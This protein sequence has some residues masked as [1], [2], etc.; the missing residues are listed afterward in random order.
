MNSINKKVKKS[1]LFLLLFI[2]GCT[3]L[4][5]PALKL[6]LNIEGTLLVRNYSAKSGNY[7]L[8][9]VS[10]LPWGW[11]STMLRISPKKINIGAYNWSNEQKKIL[12][13]CGDDWEKIC[14][15]NKYGLNYKELY[16]LDELRLE[17]QN[18]NILTISPNGKYLTLFY[19]GSDDSYKKGIY[20]FDL[21]KMEML[22]KN[23]PGDYFTEV[24]WSQDETKLVYG[25]IDDNLFIVDISTMNIQFVGKGYSSAW[26]LDGKKLAYAQP[27]KIDIINQSGES[28]ETIA[29]D[30][31]CVSRNGIT[32]D[33]SGTKILLISSCSENDP[34][35][36]FFIFDI[37]NKEL[38][39]LHWVKWLAPISQPGWVP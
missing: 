21:M 7:S 8:N 37:E 5:T 24:V 34:N 10:S 13:I 29:L 25:N 14:E 20:F 15:I 18:W 27:H 26:T 12:F 2:V 4:I 6:Y 3:I 9:I 33:P 39:K 17:K 11:E 30:K 32:W 1:L 36:G 35:F 23:I 38:Q 31:I 16:G 28:L 22:E 19:I